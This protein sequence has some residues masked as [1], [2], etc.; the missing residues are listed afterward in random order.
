[1]VSMRVRVFQCLRT[2]MIDGVGRFADHL[3]G[4]TYADTSEVLKRSITLKNVELD[5]IRWWNVFK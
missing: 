5:I 2:E 4:V 3:P 1:M